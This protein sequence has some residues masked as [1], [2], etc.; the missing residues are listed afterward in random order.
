MGSVAALVVFSA[1][2]IF[3]LRSPIRPT[4]GSARPPLTRALVSPVLC[5]S[6][7]ASFPHG[8]SG[9]GNIFPAG[10]LA[11]VVPTRLWSGFSHFPEEHQDAWWLTELAR[12]AKSIR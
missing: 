8:L 6:Q 7:R 3:F 10:L 4:Y 12:I 2:S 1:A 11:P 9:L 5:Y